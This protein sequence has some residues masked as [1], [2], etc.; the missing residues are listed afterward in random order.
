MKRDFGTPGAARPRFNV[1]TGRELDPSEIA[2]R[3]RFAVVKVPDD[4]G[5]GSPDIRL[6]E[7]QPESPVDSWHTRAKRAS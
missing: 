5:R 7:D 3:E 1:V 6:R 4:R 2:G